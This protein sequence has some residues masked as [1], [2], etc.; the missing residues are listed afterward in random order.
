[1]VGAHLLVSRPVGGALKHFF[2]ELHQMLQSN[3]LADLPSWVL[4][5]AVLSAWVN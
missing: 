1:M 5:S 3:L 2:Q 4:D